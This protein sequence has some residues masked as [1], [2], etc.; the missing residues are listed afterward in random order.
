MKPIFT[1]L[2]KNGAK[3]EVLYYDK[4]IKGEY[5]LDKIQVIVSPEGSKPRGWLMTAEADE[6]NAVTQGMKDLPSLLSY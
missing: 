1:S 3:I 2:W 6:A 5:K 4:P